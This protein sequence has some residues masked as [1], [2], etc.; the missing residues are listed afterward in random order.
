MFGLF[1]IFILFGLSKLDSF[2]NNISSTPTVAEPSTPKPTSSSGNFELF[3]NQGQSN[4]TGT[5]ESVSVRLLDGTTKVE[6][7]TTIKDL[8]LKNGYIIEK[9]D[10]ATNTYSQTMIYYK[11][12]QLVQGQDATDVLKTSFSPQLQESSALDKSYDLLIIVGDK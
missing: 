11:K 4:L 12:G 9:Q 1:L 10:K 2:T 3:D 6:N 7:I 8:L 5:S